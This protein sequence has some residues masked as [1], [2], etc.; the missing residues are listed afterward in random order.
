MTA[1]PDG[2]AST[3]PALLPVSPGD[4]PRPLSGFVQGVLTVHFDRGAVATRHMPQCDARTFLAK[5]KGS[6]NDDCVT[7]DTEHWFSWADQRVVFYAFDVDPDQNWDIEPEDR[8]RLVESGHRQGVITSLLRFWRRRGRIDEPT[9]SPRAIAVL[10]QYALNG[11]G[12]HEWETAARVF[13]GAEGAAKIA[14]V[15]DDQPHLFASDDVEPETVGDRQASRD[16]QSSPDH[17]EVP[18]DPLTG[19]AARE[20]DADSFDVERD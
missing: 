15:G 1:I 8:R 9:Y 5:Q 18:E 16:E 7:W 19:D 11:P 12:L 10:H 6:E 14:R 13:E 3:A 17:V 20:V 4:I 2:R